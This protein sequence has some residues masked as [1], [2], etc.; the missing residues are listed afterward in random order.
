M[1]AN[2]ARTIDLHAIRF[3]DRA[4]LVAGDRTWTYRELARDVDAL[5][6]ALA[7]DGIGAAQRIAVVADN[8]PEFL[9]LNLALS[10]LGAV[11]VPLNYRLTAAELRHLLT[12]AR[13]DGVAVSAPYAAV[14]G[15]ALEQLAIDRRYALEE[16]GEPWQSVP[17]LIASHRGRVQPT[18]SVE[19]D[20]LQRI[21]YTSGTTS[22]PKGVL[23]THGNVNANMHA[24]IVEMGLRPGDSI[25]NFAPLYHVGG[26]DLPG[27]AIWHV[28]GTM[29]LLRR[30]DPEGIVSAILAHG[31][32][33]MVIPATVLDMIRRLEAST[34]LAE[35]HVRW[36]LF[37][38]VTPALFRTARALFPNARLIEGYGL[39]ETCG[40]LTY[41][42]EAHMESKQGSV[43][44]PL[45]WVEVRVVDADGADAPT[46]QSGEI[47]AQG[48]KVSHG[49][50]DDP[51]A[52]ARAFRN[53]WFHTGDVGYLDADGYLTVQDRLKDMIRSGAENIASAEV[54][55]VLADHPDV[56]A[57]AVVGAPDPQW[58]EVPV[59]FVVARPGFDPASLVESAGTR[60]ARFKLPKAVYV[61]EEFP[62][63]P[64]GK[65]LKRELRLL[66]ETLEPAWEY[67]PRG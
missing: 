27:Y 63:N 18:A 39:T 54:E 3:A 23:L 43:G 31:V 36:L 20:T 47:V 24:Q 59:A 38:Q 65:V 6:S 1:T 49:Y 11:S 48:P 8:V 57:V 10:K 64:S 60:L 53:G 25:L 67:V 41:L 30:A 55:H 28:G 14:V 21:I 52:T 66:R 15:E 50:L 17:A 16:I 42:D 35:S 22:L 61:V 33:G 44:L 4:A 26:T 37:S 9:I 13:V 40:G 46:G 5:A 51:E 58:Q 32:T 19:P 2:L 29:V 45:P 34:R 56:L 12:H 62:T 7:D